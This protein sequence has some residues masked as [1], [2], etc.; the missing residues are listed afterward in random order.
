MSFGSRKSTNLVLAR[1]R[2]A[3]HPTLLEYSKSPT[4]KVKH[5]GKVAVTSQREKSPIRRLPRVQFPRGDGGD[6]RHVDTSPRAPLSS[7]LRSS[8][9]RPIE[10]YDPQPSCCVP[11]S[12]DPRVQTRSLRTIQWARAE[13]D[14]SPNNNASIH[15]RVYTRTLCPPRKKNIF[16]PGSELSRVSSLPEPRWNL[17]RAIAW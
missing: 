4:R 13:R 14:S 3:V 8:P 11:Q 5:L 12:D 6:A 7:A 17:R 16:F 10:R 1:V 9:H 15:Y 2:R